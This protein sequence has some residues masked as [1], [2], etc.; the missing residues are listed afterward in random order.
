MSLFLK[1]RSFIKILIVGELILFFSIFIY[2]LLFSPNYL[3]KKSKYVVINK[4]ETFQNVI[5]RFTDEGII[6]KPLFFKVAGILFGYHNEIKMGRYLIH[7][8]ESN[9]KIL[10]RIIDVKGSETPSITILE[11]LRLREIAGYLK[12][13]AGIDSTRFMEL[14]RNY[15]YLNLP[16]KSINSLEG[17]LMPDT[18]EILWQTD[19]EE[20]IKRMVREFERFY[21]DSLKQRAVQLRMSLKDVISLASIIEGETK[22]KSERSIVSGVYHNRL[23]IRMALQADPTIQYIISNGPRRLKYSDLKINSPYN[24]YIYTG[25]PPGPINNPGRASIIAALY[26]AKHKYFYFVANGLGGH[27]FSTTFDMHNENVAKF[28]KIRADSLRKKIL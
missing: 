8:G 5:T 13:R 3:N 19:E 6:S 26:P 14:S 4:N 18:Y 7:D 15:S 12:L 20:I 10:E 2:L 22:L 16:T 27:N 17:F 1:K 21:H 28:R 25:L 24:T 23:R 11:G 9:Y